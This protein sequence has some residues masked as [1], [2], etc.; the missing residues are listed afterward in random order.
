[1]AIPSA[2]SRV[3][4]GLLKEA[5]DLTQPP[6][7]REHGEV[8]TSGSGRATRGAGQLPSPPRPIM[9]NIDGSAQ[10]EAMAR[11]LLMHA[12]HHRV[13]GIAAVGGEHRVDVSGAI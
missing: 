1:M 11:K 9:V 3:G 6:I 12:C 7:R 5:G 13:Q 4:S 2:P 10:P 8:N